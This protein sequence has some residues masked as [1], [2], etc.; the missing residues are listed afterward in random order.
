MRLQI[1][2]K[3]LVLSRTQE[4]Q[5]QACFDINTD[6]AADMLMAALPHKSPC[7]IAFIGAGCC[8]AELRL[9]SEVRNRGVDIPHV[10]FLDK[11]FTTGAI[12]RVHD[13]MEKNTKDNEPR[14]AMVFTFRDLNAWL[15]KRQKNQPKHGMIVLGINARMDFDTP[16][17][18]YDCHA[19][20][21]NCAKWARQN[22][23]N[24]QYLN[25]RMSQN[26]DEKN[27]R[28]HQYAHEQWCYRCSW[29][30]I[31]SEI[32][33]CTAASMLLVGPETA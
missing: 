24:A 18:L 31:A 8:D 14:P 1:D 29:W 10:A 22:V 23:V 9:L 15:Q 5:C 13:Y 32:I 12:R 26:K 27:P 2:G 21:C 3:V 25:F 17:D 6:A 20:M 16:E 4:D 33:S 11:A 28:M 7:C 30:E 19:F